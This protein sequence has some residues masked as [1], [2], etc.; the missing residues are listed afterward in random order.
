MMGR[1]LESRISKLEGRRARTNE[2][3]VVWRRPDG[4]VAE[5]LKGTSFAKGDKVVCAE[6]FEDGPMPAPRWYRD[7]LSNA[8]TT[9]EYEQLNRT[10]DRLV[11]QS[12]ANRDM[13]GYAPF[14]AFSEERMK[15]MTDGELVHALLGVMT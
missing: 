10:I 1:G 6:W 5:A 4:G 13:S 15:Q 11:S 7:R 12:D 14:P 2:M 9:A 3:L 8:M